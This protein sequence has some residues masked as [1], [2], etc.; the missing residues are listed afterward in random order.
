LNF[1]NAKNFTDNFKGLILELDIGDKRQDLLKGINYMN[2]N[3]TLINDDAISKL[4]NPGKLSKLKEFHMKHTPLVTR[5]GL[6][7][8][9]ENKCSSPELN[10]F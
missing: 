1:R 4:F 8:I 2:F 5:E 3:R 6:K 10:I 7:T 9:I